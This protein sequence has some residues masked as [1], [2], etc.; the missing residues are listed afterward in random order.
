[1]K[2]TII[3]LHLYLNVLAF[4]YREPSELFWPK[5]WHAVRILARQVSQRE[6]F[7]APTRLRQGGGGENLDYS[8][9]FAVGVMDCPR[10]VP[11]AF[12]FVGY[13]GYCGQT[14]A[15]S[16]SIERV[17]RRSASS[18]YKHQE[19]AYL[20]DQTLGARAKLCGVLAWLLNL[21]SIPW[22][23]ISAFHSASSARPT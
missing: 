23:S 7:P 5:T 10:T 16:D 22:A 2:R 3:A 1:M 4:L 14:S 9:S 6:A 8:Y 18:T 13:C 20:F 17:D 11:H 15:N 21:Q 19:C 12:C